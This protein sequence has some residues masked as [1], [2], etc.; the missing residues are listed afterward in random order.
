MNQKI[1]SIILVTLISVTMLAGIPICISEDPDLP[2][3]EITS[4][5]RIGKTFTAYFTNN[6][7]ADLEVDVDLIWWVDGD[8][9]IESE[10]TW[11]LDVNENRDKTDS[12][13]NYISPGWHT[14]GFSL[15]YDETRIMEETFSNNYL[16]DTYYFLT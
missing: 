2:D 10:W 7:E 3:I 12:L 11:G 6:G 14:I 15:N 1:L 5:S 9:V 4:I 16:E 8:E 13:S